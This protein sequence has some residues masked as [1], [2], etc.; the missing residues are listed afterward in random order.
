MLVELNSPTFY[1]EVLVTDDW[2][3]GIKASIK[4]VK[5]NICNVWV[6]VKSALPQ[7]VLDMVAMRAKREY[8]ARQNKQKNKEVKQ[9]TTEPMTEL[10]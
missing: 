5:V 1:A 8:R 3:E 10:P 6:D 9:Q 4:E 7:F 2:Y